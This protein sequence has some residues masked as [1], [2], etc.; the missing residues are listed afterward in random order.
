[1]L[2]RS[3]LYQISERMRE[4]ANTSDLQPQGPRFESQQLQLTDRDLRE[5]KQTTTPSKAIARRPAQHSRRKGAH[6]MESINLKLNWFSLNLNWFHFFEIK[7]R[8]FMKFLENSRFFNEIQRKS[9]NRKT[10]E[11]FHCVLLGTLVLESMEIWIESKL[12]NRNQ[13]KFNEN[14]FKFKVP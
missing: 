3:T 6:C 4:R 13:F 1:M 11:N 7:S 14:Q 2:L 5:N 10:F 12:S 8:F 9:R